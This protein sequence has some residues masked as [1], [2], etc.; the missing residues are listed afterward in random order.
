MILRITDLTSLHGEKRARTH[1]E[2]DLPRGTY[3]ASVHSFSLRNDV[4]SQVAAVRPLLF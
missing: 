4:R 3:A 1:S 2:G